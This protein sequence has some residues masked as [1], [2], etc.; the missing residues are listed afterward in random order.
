MSRSPGSSPTTQFRDYLLAV[1]LG[2]Q[3]RISP[4]LGVSGP[5]SD[6]AAYGTPSIARQRPAWPVDVDTPG[7]HRSAAR[8]TSAR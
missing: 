7:V 1:D 5:L 6:M 2:L 4:L 3:L 8:T